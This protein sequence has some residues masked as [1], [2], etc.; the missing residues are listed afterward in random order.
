[1][2]Y[3]N[4]KEQLLNTLNSINN[5]KHKDNIQII[6]VDD[7][8]TN[9]YKLNLNE[10]LIINKN[11]ELITL[12][13]ETKWYTN[14]CIPFNIGFKKIK[15]NNVIIQNS[16]CYHNGDIIDYVL[17]NLNNNNYLSFGCY[18]LTENQDLNNINITNKIVSFDG[19]NG[20]YNHSTIRPVYYHFCS[21]I[22][23][24]N[25]KKLGGFDERF[26]NGIGYDDNEL[27][28]RIDR[29]GLTKTIIDTPNVFHQYHYNEKS[30]NNGIYNTDLYNLIKTETWIN[31]NKK[32]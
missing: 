17:N 26:A 9:N 7:C 21:A 6:I 2:T 24:E 12:T 5:S 3:Y 20:W 25:L 23:H 16:E 18:S 32:Q 31:P 28:I 22:T 29:L 1:M 4:R 30:K 19:D 11:I 13:K 14:P 8:S 10:L 27:L 15:N